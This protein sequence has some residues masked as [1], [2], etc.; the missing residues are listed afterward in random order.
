MGSVDMDGLHQQSAQISGFVFLVWLLN[1]VNNKVQP[2]QVVQD[3]R[4]E[5]NKTLAEK[6]LLFLLFVSY[7]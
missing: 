2:W 1:H 6:L 4:S 7:F 5:D 3:Q